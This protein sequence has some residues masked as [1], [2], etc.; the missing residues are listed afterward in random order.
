M[1][2]DTGPYAS[3]AWEYRQAGYAGIIPLGREPGQKSPPPSKYTGWAG[4]DPSGPDVQTWVD[5]PQGRR[6]IGW[7]LPRGYVGVDVDAYHRG[8]ESLAKLEDK[9]GTP[10]QPTWTS[11]AR[12]QGSISRHHFYQAPLPEGRTWRDHPGDGIDSLHV[13]HRYAMVWPSLNPDHQ[14]EMVCW[15]DPSGELYE[16]VP[17]PAWFTVLDEAWI[18]E[19]S[20]EGVPLEGAGA[21]DSTTARSLDRMRPGPACPRVAA[22]L[23]K[24]LDRIAKAA[25]G[26]GSL[27]EPGGLYPLVAYGLEGHAGVR[28]ALSTHQATY[29]KARSDGR[30]ETE[31]VGDA[32]WW[33]QVRGAVGKRLHNRDGLARECECAKEELPPEEPAG[34][35]D[36]Q[37]LRALLLDRDALDL[38]PPVTPL[39][40]G[41]L[42]LN[43]ESWIIGAPGGFK[44]FVALDW[45]LHVVTGLP[46]RG[47]RVAQGK[48]VYMVAEGAKGIKNRVAAWEQQYGHRATNVLF[49]PLPVQ[50]TNARS[51]TAWVELCRQEAPVLVV[52]DT[53]ARITVGV[54]ENSNGQMSVLTEA[55]RQL[56]EA[57]GACVLV[58]HHT[59]RNGQDAR[60]ASAVD[61][62]QDVEWRIDRPE[63]RAK[64]RL[65]TAKLSCDK[66]KDGSDSEAFDFTM[67]IKKVGVDPED[68]RPVTSLALD[69]W[70]PMSS[71]EQAPP[72]WRADLDGVAA[73]IMEV[74][75]DH[76]GEMGATF[77]EIDRWVLER[78][79]ERSGTGA[80]PPLLKATRSSAVL[81]LCA[82]GR[83]N[84]DKTVYLLRLGAARVVL[85]E[86]ADPD[87]VD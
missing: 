35:D 84:A 4:I 71:P 66:S 28:E 45:A 68:G 26:V 74:M 60:G 22:H 54:D 7:H 8:A 18:A 5:G 23:G 87:K 78:R 73:E 62:A 72:Q 3:A 14:M 83:K 47:K 20:Q 36:V 30:G 2:D 49:L 27:H 70:D 81:A 86:Y 16:G 75:T 33:R 82:D 76:S 46:W 48:A 41:V 77:A 10:L 63:G 32:D 55:V 44:S 42:D 31:A 67:E 79:K 56:K 43:S 25:A 24:E 53:Q 9:I 6:N 85:P 65:L 50:V 17:D 15:Y 64:R 12:G 80:A 51:W 57:T 19:L 59:G 34:V 69:L 52:L 37:A 38:V 40:K 21:S 29:V 39:I 13:G 1:T 61:G 58:V 11:T